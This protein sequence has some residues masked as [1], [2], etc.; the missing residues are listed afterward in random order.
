M[1]SAGGGSDRP[2]YVRRVVRIPL[3]RVPRLGQHITITLQPPRA[4]GQ[5]RCL[6]SSKCVYFVMGG[7]VTGGQQPQIRVVPVRGSQ[8]T[9]PEA[10]LQEQEEATRRAAEDSHRKSQLRRALSINQ[11]PL[12]CVLPRNGGLHVQWCVLS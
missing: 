5:G 10:E 6:Y 9:V 7:Y 4:Q 2:P 12:V 11:P 8:Q 1:A 3:V